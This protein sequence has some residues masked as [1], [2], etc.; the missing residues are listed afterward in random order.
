V[1]T[2][3]CSEAIRRHQCD[4]VAALILGRALTATLLAAAQLG[5][6]E[7]LNAKWGYQGTLRT[8]MADAGSDGVCRGFIAPPSVAE[9]ASHAESLYGGNALLQVVRF[10]GDQILASGTVEAPLHDVVDDLDYFHAISDQVEFATMAVMAFSADP[11]DPVRLCRGLMLHPLPDA[12]L[13]EF[14]KLRNRMRDPIFRDFLTRLDE[15]DNHL[16]NLLNL[17]ALPDHGPDIQVSA[18]PEPV[19]RCRC[20]REKMGGVLR[21]LSYED[22]MDIVRKQEPVAISCRMCNERYVLSIEECIQVWNNRPLDPAG[23]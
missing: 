6:E 15:T 13:G 17:A 7:R 9:M 3:L 23:G 22:R 11:D 14:E 21:A 5:P 10:R 20:S 2:R 1:T 19:F 12:D 4:P 16:E 8:V 18:C